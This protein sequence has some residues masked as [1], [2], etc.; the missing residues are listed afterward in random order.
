MA[1]FTMATV[2]A[3]VLT[4]PVALLGMLSPRIDPDE[5]LALQAAL[6]S[7][8]LTTEQ[9]RA[10]N[11]FINDR[12]IA[13]DLDSRHL[14]RGS[15]LIDE[16]LGYAIVLA[17]AYPDQFVITSDRDFKNVVADPAGTGV[18]Y[19]LVPATTNL[20]S[21][22]ALNSA[23]PRVYETGAGIGTLEAS[24]ADGSDYRDDWRLYSINAKH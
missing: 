10:S 22:D 8:Q 17:S 23:Y 15:V 12:A 1:G 4:L 21:L 14:P 11:R 24:Y 3:L 6:N 5:G 9:Q 16:F 20:G 18:K 2:A 19:M 13:G 7:G